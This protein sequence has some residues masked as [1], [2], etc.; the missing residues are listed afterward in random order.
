MSFLFLRLIPAGRGGREMFARLGYDVNK[1]IRRVRWQAWNET[2]CRRAVWIVQ[3]KVRFHRDYWS[4]TAGM[5]CSLT[6]FWGRPRYP[7]LWS[8][9]WQ[10]SSSLC[11]CVCMCGVNLKAKGW[12]QCSLWPVNSSR[13]CRQH[14]TR[15]GGQM[16]GQ[17]RNRTS[18]NTGFHYCRVMI[19]H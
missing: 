9:H 15:E 18:S 11:L 2:S 19:I 12:V 7:F 6:S 13:A 10:I 16:R 4:T 5:G 1:W 3:E 14:T 17:Q 8:Y